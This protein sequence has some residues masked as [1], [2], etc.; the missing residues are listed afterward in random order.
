MRF[1][2]EEQRAVEA[3]GEVRLEHSNG[4]ALDRLVRAGAA[5]KAGELRFVARRRDDKAALTRGHRD[6]LRPIGQRLLAETDDQRFRALAFTP[7]R[8]H[9][10]GI[11]GAAPPWSVVLLDQL[12]LGAATSELV[13]RGQAGNPG[14]DHPHGWAGS[15]LRKCWGMRHLGHH[16]YAGMIRIRFEGSPRRF[17]NLVGLSTPCRGSPGRH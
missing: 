3:A 13:S 6:G 5:G 4:I 2:G 9:A 10:A 11:V 17:Q 7:G 14:A 16:P 1:L 15:V 12:D 8:Q